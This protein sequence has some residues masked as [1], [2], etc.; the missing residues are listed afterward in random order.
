MK[1]TASGGGRLKVVVVGPVSGVSTSPANSPKADIDV[2]IVDREP[3]PLPA[4]AVPVATGIM[5]EGLI[6]PALRRVVRGQANDA[7]RLRD[8][9]L[10]AFE[11]AEVTARTDG[12]RSPLRHTTIAMDDES[13]T[14]RVSDG[15]ERIPAR[16]KV[17]AAGVKAS[18]L[19]GL[20]AR[21]TGAETDRAGRIAGGTRLHSARPSRGVRDR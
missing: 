18:P 1:I 21:A 8:R 2:T 3:P 11:L 9:I 16:T 5:P 19:A 13:I 12:N 7:R 14:V 10:G 4:P 6:A 20:L 15:E 17:W